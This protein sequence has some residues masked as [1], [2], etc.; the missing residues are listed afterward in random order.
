MPKT[1]SSRVARDPSS[2]QTR[3]STLTDWFGADGLLAHATPGYEDRPGQQRMAEQIAQAIA[4]GSPLAVERATGVGKSF[5]YLIAIITSRQKALVA[6][7]TKLLQDQLA[8][9]DLP[10]LQDVLRSAGLR[11]F[12]FAVL[13][14]RHNYVCLLE[15]ERTQ[16]DM[17]NNRDLFETPDH[18]D[19]WPTITAWVQHEAAVG[20]LAELDRS[21]IDIPPAIATLITTTSHECLGKE[22]PLVDRCFAERAKRLA[23]QAQIV[24]VNAHLLLIDAKLWGETDGA[25]SLLPEHPIA[26]VDEA[27]TLESVAS[28]IFGAEIGIGR[29]RWLHRQ[30]QRLR[31]ATPSTVRELLVQ[32][33]TQPT[34]MDEAIWTADDAIS[35]ATERAK[36]QFD[37]W[38]HEMGDRVWMPM[39]DEVHDLLGDL[40][41]ITQALTQVLTTGK[42]SKLAPDGLQR[43]RT[44][45]NAAESLQR[46]VQRALEP[47][48]NMARFLERVEGRFPRVTMKVVPIEVSGLLNAY[49]WSQRPT[50]IATSATLRTSGSFDYW[51]SR[52]GLVASTSTLTIPSPFQYQHQARLFI[53][54]PPAQFEPRYPGHAQY[55]PYVERIGRTLLELLTASHGRALVLCTTA[56]AM[57]QRAEHLKPLVPWTI[58]VQGERSRP[59]L[60]DE[61]RQDRHSI[62]FATKSFWQGVDV[63]GDALSLLII[64][65]LPFANLDD[66]VFSARSARIEQQHG[67]GSSF[68][69]LSL[70]QMV[71]DLRQGIGRLI[72]RAT[73]LGVIA[74]LDGRPLTKGYGSYILRS[75]PPAPRISQVAEVAQF[76][77]RGGVG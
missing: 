75:L 46:D 28:S 37:V 43:W 11:E 65:R 29:W 51:L 68:S 49:L 27:H 16:Q 39:P 73:D 62:L 38:R 23:K 17:D 19:L 71:L 58:L 24:V 26:I 57:H 15:F 55:A 1:I 22:C 31:K 3:P 30:L 52:V 63:L 45:A 4:H 10:F 50:T 72:R 9:K 61:F 59:F 64:D 21:R 42:A 6:T 40:H 34:T 67:Q 5:A 25:V 41:T 56:E 60:L 7:E 14:G 33:D 76:L 12:S 13:K 35:R 44:L 54:D 47:S 20:G 8:Q 2:G 74:I 69:R 70:P 48:P 18:A 32:L 53:P 77:A 66:P 36:T